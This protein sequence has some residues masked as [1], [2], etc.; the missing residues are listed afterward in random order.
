MSIR[1]KVILPYLLLTL[2]IAV[3]GVYVVTRLVTNSL[4]ER[5]TN[6]LL[7]AGRVVSD[8]FARQEVTHVENAR[9]IAYTVGV[10]EALRDED[11]K[12][13]VALT[14]P[15]M[16]GF[17]VEDLIFVDAQGAELAHLFRQADGSIK[18][19]PIQ[20]NS[21]SYSLVQPIL[22]SN[23]PATLPRRGI[24]Q[25]PV[26]GQYYYF[27]AIPVALNEQLIGAVVIG[28]SIENILPY[29]KSTSLA[30]V[31]LYTENGQAIG[32]TLVGDQD[33]P[34]FL[35]T[36]S[37]S[38]ELY[39]QVINSNLTVS[40]ENLQLLD[41]PYSLARG[42]LQ[43][44]D[45]RLGVF[46]VVLPSEFVLQPG[47]TNR[48]MSIALFTA[49]MLGVIL[50]GYLI[51]RLIINP[52]F[53]LV[54]TSQAI[55][56]GDLTQRTGIQSTDEI[57]TLANTFDSMTIRLQERTNE[58]ERTYK[59]LEQMDRTKVS[60]IEVSAHELRTP[61]TLIKG[62]TQMLQMRSSS[63]PELTALAQGI[64]D[65]SN[66]MMEIV[67]NMLDVTKIDS[68]TLKIVP[69]SIH[70]GLLM[71]RVQKTFKTA[72]QERNLLL[73]TQ[74]LD[75]L[76]TIQADPDLIYKVF[77]HLV[78]NAIKYTPNG[79]SITVRGQVI[80][81]SDAPQVEIV[82][83]DTGIGIDPRYQDLI[84]E[85]FFQ[86]GEVQT[87]SSGKTKFKGGGPGLG[88]AIARGI[89]E[90]HGGKIWVESA[91]YNEQTL[92]GSHFH[93]LLPVQRSES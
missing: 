34:Q 50:I 4:S 44:S 77:Y 84:F 86:T 38:N 23:N 88:L 14:K 26:N 12:T 53:S 16:I 40:G 63:D 55:A 87:H 21:I 83:S 69:E 30:D 9:L 81:N 67:N 93:V 91:G 92:P 47:A 54:R 89:V 80:E 27:T 56:S 79:G 70:L 52:L 28:T 1:I 82:V 78:I 41:R 3:T 33:G 51:S 72:L 39:Q 36:L 58:L 65:G 74:N 43:V 35:Q 61:L 42:P 64:L 19:A 20:A 48:N 75:L 32:T 59:I 57:G 62:Y 13:L 31:I 37:I 90:A 45:D 5:L 18:E 2:V 10:A 68:K 29:L 76:P 8:D 22:E 46:A 25:N 15:A 85:K 66:R 6:Q 71:M 73:I 24:G 49:A 7:E 60:F 11:R 17:N